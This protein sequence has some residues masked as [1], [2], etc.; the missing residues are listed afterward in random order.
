MRGGTTSGVIYPLAVCA[1]AEHYTFRNV[2]GASAGAIGAATTA[3][4]EYGRY[5]QPAAPVT[6]EA[7][8]PGF[9]GWPG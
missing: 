7:V 6:G 9:A 4:A 8:H 5:R 1:L 3:A 2:G